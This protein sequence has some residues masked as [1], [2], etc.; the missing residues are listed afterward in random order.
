M[1]SKH[2]VLK[3]VECAEC[4][5]LERQP[6]ASGFVFCF[7]EEKC[8]S[9]DAMICNE[10]W[11]PVNIQFTLHGNLDRFKTHPVKTNFKSPVRDYKDNCTIWP[12]GNPISNVEILRVIWALRGHLRLIHKNEYTETYCPQGLQ[13]CFVSLLKLG[14][15]WDLTLNP[16]SMFLT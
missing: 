13:V 16:F 6:S 12:G 7:T 4:P 1:V 10:Q 2:L 8:R 14:R 3:N 15:S 5:K 9:M 11:T